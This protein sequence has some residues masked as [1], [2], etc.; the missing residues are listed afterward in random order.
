MSDKILKSGPAGLDPAAV[1]ARVL[2]REAYDATVDAHGI[3]ENA[4]RQAQAI[5]VEAQRQCR[6]IREA[7][8]E[9]GYR[10]GLGRWNEALERAAAAGENLMTEHQ[11]ELVTLAVR[12]AEKIIGEELR[13]RPE[14]ILG[15]VREA[16]QSVRRER[17]LTIQVNPEHVETVRNRIDALARVAGVG[18][19]IQV[20][21]DPAVAPG[22]CVV[23]SELGIIDAQLETQLRCLEETLLRAAR[24]P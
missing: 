16:L 24:K 1:A 5:I 12:L 9:E 3:V 22:G 11:A 14:T 4:E 8:R 6:E 2:K 10:E 23:E 18:R 7:A 19:E 21:A 15:I 17:M 20:V 13:S